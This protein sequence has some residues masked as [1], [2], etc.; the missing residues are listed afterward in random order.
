MLYVVLVRA[1]FFEKKKQP[2]YEGN[3]ALLEGCQNDVR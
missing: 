2:F 1:G 3:F